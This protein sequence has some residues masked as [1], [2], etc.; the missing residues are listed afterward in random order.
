[1]SAN[2]DRHI[3]KRAPAVDVVFDVQFEPALGERELE[4]LRDAFSKAYSQVIPNRNFHIDVNAKTVTNTVI[5]Y[6]LLDSEGTNIVVLQKG[7]LATGRVAPYDRWEN[8]RGRAETN[9]KVLNKVAGHRK[10]TR[11]GLRY[12]NRIDVPTAEAQSPSEV[13]NAYPLVP[14]PWAGMVTHYSARHES[15][16]RE[17]GV[18][19][20]LNVAD[21]SPA[22]INHV[23]YLLDIDV[24]KIGDIPSKYEDFWELGEL[25]HNEKNRLFEACITDALR[26]KFDQ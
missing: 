11:V 1:M 3:Y 22:L 16:N 2:P 17:T 5:G 19:T 7:G 12:V 8:M 6:R 26:R 21:A 18:T 10:F 23:S 13:L 20:I 4:R 14:E 15:L 24:L 25:L 9:L